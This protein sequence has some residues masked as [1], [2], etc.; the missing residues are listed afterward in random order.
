MDSP[1]H[2]APSSD[3]S[4]PHIP[5]AIAAAAS[6]FLNMGLRIHDSS[7]DPFFMLF[8]AR[9]PFFMHDLLTLSCWPSS[10]SKFMALGGPNH[11]VAR[12]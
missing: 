8:H 4:Q 10:A 5:I 12:E 2:P 1:D 6:F 7:P 9:D 11:Y 3:K